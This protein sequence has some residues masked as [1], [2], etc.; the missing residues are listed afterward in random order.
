MAAAVRELNGMGFLTLA[1]ALKEGAE[2]MQK[3]RESGRL[4][5]AVGNEGRGLPEGVTE[6]CSGTVII[7]MS[8]KVESLNANAAASILMWELRERE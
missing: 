5:I 3:V 6:A 8:G 7:P 4:F 2:P 1:S